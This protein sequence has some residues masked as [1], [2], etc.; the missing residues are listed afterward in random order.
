MRASRDDQLV[1][2]LLLELLAWDVCESPVLGC[3]DDLAAREL[4]LGAAA[5]LECV[6]DKVLLC[7]HGDEDLS[8]ADAGGC[9]VGLTV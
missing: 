6:W 1:L 7:A 4:E 9:A 3:A 8:D 2:H 5:G